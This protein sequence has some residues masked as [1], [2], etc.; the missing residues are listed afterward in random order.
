M[1]QSPSFAEAEAEADENCTGKDYAGDNQQQVYI[2][3]P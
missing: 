1:W 3:V 2:S